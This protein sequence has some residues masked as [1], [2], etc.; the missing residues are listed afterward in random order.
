[1][2]QLKAF[3]GSMLLALGLASTPSHASIIKSL[4]IEEIGLAS[5][6]LG[7]SA[8]SNAGGEFFA[9]GSPADSGFISAGSL[10]GAIIMGQAQGLNAF[11]TGFTFSGIP[12]LPHTLGGAPTGSITGGTLVL[13][14]SGWGTLWANLD[15]ILFPDPGTLVTSIAQLDAKRYYYTAD[16]SHV[17]T[18]AETPPFAGFPVSWHL[19]GIATVPEP[20]TAWLV[21]AA[22][23]GWLGVRRRSLS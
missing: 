13:D 4:T 7:T 8:L 1:M 3:A 18:S 17:I 5:G 23:L 10:D 6:G 20:G 15:F 12:A 9:A 21:G 22:L 19:E 11:T 2:Y 16:W 14:L